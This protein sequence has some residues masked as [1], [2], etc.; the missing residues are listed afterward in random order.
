MDELQQAIVPISFFDNVDYTFENDEKNYMGDLNE[1]FINPYNMNILY[2]PKNIVEPDSKIIDEYSN[3]NKMARKSY[4]VMNIEDIVVSSIYEFVSD[5]AYSCGLR[6]GDKS[7][8]GFRTDLFNA[9]CA[10]VVNNNLLH[11]LL[12]QNTENISYIDIT[13]NNIYTLITRDIISKCV[14]ITTNFIMS[15]PFNYFKQ[16]YITHVYEGEEI[17][18]EDAGKIADIYNSYGSSLYTSIS[19]ILRDIMEVK[20]GNLRRMFDV[21]KQTYINMGDYF[22]TYSINGNTMELEASQKGKEYYDYL[23]NDK[24]QI[25]E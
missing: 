17:D 19:S 4:L 1:I 22:G 24:Y 12:I 15:S 25:K 8:I 5:V 23:I 9:I 18:I 16:F 11:N 7:T 10:E 6:R 21:V 3:C 20:L 13:L 2:K 14:F